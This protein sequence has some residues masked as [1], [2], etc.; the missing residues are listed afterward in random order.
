V[1]DKTH[2]NLGCGA[3]AKLVEILK[4]N[5][6]MVRGRS[7]ET[8]LEFHISMFARPST[9]SILFEGRLSMPR[10]GPLLAGNRE[11]R[12][13]LYDRHLCAKS[14]YFLLH[15][16]PN[17]RFCKGIKGYLFLETCTVPKLNSDIIASFRHVE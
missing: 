15:E 9:R 17:M 6:E 3:I 16:G 7:L 1:T 10:G 5:L 8:V 11:C 13:A 2:R 4:G 12:P 14:S